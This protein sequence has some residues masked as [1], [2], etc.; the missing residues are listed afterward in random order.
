M[1]YYSVFNFISLMTNKVDH[2]FLCLLVIYEVSVK[3]FGSHFYGAYFR[4]Y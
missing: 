3:V 4:F 2:L 1:W